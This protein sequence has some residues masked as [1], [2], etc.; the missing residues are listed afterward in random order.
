[1]KKFM[2]MLQLVVFYITPVLSIKPA[3]AQNTLQERP[4]IG[5]VLS[6]G[7]ARGA[8]HVG[9]IKILEEHKIPVDVI[10]G[11][12]FGAIVGGLYATGYSAK[13]LEYILEGMD[14]EA[15]L[16]NEAPRKYKSFRRKE[17]DEGFLIKFKLGI[18]DWDFTLP[19]SLINPNNL[20]LTLRDIVGDASLYENFDQL[21]IPFR[22]VAT[23]LQT[24]E[25]VI[26]DR[27]DLAMALVSSMAVPALFPPV[28]YKDTLLVDGGV[29]NNIPIDLAREMGADVVIVVDVSGEMLKK[30]ELNDFASVLDQ[31]SM[32]QTHRASNEQLKTLRPLDVVIRPELGDLTMANFDKTLEMVPIGEEAASKMLG[33]LEYLALS[34]KE[35]LKHLKA[36]DKRPEEPP[37]I[38]F[39]Q[40]ENESDIANEVLLAN[41]SAK[42]GQKLNTKDIAEDLTTIYGLGLFDE[43]DY[44]NIRRGDHFGLR[45]K[46]KERQNGEDYFRFGV[47]LSDNFEGD[48]GYQLGVNFTN[49]ALN[50]YGGEWQ[51]QFNI[52]E[53]FSLATEVYQPVDYGE[54]LYLFANALGAKFNRNILANNSDQIINQVRISTARFSAGLGYNFANW[55]TFRIGLQRSYA[56]IAGRIG[57]PPNFKVNGDVTDLAALFSVDTLNSTKFPRSGLAIDIEYENGQSWFGGDSRV[58]TITANMYKPYSWG[59]NT[60]GLSTRLATSFNGTP[61]ETNLFPLGGFLGLTAYAPGQ[62][63]GNHTGV[64]TLIYYRRIFG[65]GREI[66]G[67]PIYIGGTIETGNAWNG[68]SDISLNDL[69]WSSSLFIGADT[70]LGPVY[71]GGG[72]GDGGQASAFLNIGQLF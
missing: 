29:V 20:K 8:A 22:A 55:G 23:D 1:M 56:S 10:T 65:D 28:E 26:L 35:W 53:N 34:E 59:K 71:L 11:T 63:T 40:I 16:S 21:P 24:G 41:L 50:E 30:E 64:L 14:W 66:A 44:E 18:K 13:E 47:A 5:L 32:I 2:I 61:D 46:T 38:D 52:G 60:L 37:I 51:A 69:R 72:I 70:L 3:I 45:I 27:G 12:S 39:I 15:T 49:L 25:E 62:L 68:S 31:I 54:N 4:K 42:P 6:G 19:N 43:V 48:S 58:D 33:K 7:G 57:F 17:D 67:T 9:V 36:R